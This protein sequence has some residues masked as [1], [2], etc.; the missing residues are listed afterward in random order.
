MSIGDRVKRARKSAGLTQTE[1]GRMVG[2]KQATISDL[3]K[4]ASRSSAYLVQIARACNVSTDWL[5][6]GKGEMIELQ[7]PIATYTS[8]EVAPGPAMLSQ[9]PEISWVQAG[10]F[11]EICF[12]DLDPES[13]NWYPR[14]PNCGPNTYALKV[15]GESMLDKYPPG[16]IIFV[17]PDVPA[18]SG[19]DVIAIMTETGEA[20]FK[21]YLEEPGVGRMLKARNPAWKDPYVTINGNCRVQGVVMAQMELRQR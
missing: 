18:E 19:D 6:T 5:A 16:R 15:V 21:Q 2:V 20:T 10:S 7:E 4:G 1:L 13:T 14:P 9:V 8:G 17:D 12:V 3:E 11:T